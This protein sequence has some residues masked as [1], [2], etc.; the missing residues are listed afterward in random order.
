MFA[1]RTLT[2]LTEIHDDITVVTNETKLVVNISSEYNISTEEK[3]SVLDS[4]EPSVEIEID[5]V[6]NDFKLG[7]NKYSSEIWTD[8]LNPLNE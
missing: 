6:N 3:N 1:F 8:H 7:T 5:S 4:L 2:G